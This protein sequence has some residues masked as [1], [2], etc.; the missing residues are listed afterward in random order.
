MKKFPQT[1]TAKT[2][3]GPINASKKK[4]EKPWYIT[5]PWGEFEIY[6]SIA[7]VR[8]EIKKLVDR[9]KAEK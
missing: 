8:S 2:S 9:D 4:Q 1:I 3:I 5:H 6:G 7:E